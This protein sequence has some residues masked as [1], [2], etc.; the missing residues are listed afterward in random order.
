MDSKEVQLLKR[1]LDRQKKARL[2]A[3]KI[4]EEK[5]KELYDVSHYLKE[6]NAILENKLNE[7]TS[8]LDGV[9][10]NIIDPYVVMDLAFNVINMNTSAKEFL[11]F[12]NVKQ[13]LNLSKF[14]HPDFLAY[15]AMSMKTLFKV[16][17]L[18]NYRAQIII[19]DGTMKWVQIN[20][21][22]IYNKERK[23]VA[24]QGILRDIT[25]EMEIKQLLS[26]QKKQLDIIVENSPLGILLT[27]NGCVVKMR[28][29][30][31]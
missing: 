26:K 13:N 5:S 14:I 9:F 1:A 18:K 22:V 3:E 10:I 28:T 27:E 6:A 19:R 16:G 29:C 12:D 8:E 11:G 31:V 20:C 4:L 7:K 2:Q 25:Q 17:I 21:N 24:A 15:T 30:Q 23:P